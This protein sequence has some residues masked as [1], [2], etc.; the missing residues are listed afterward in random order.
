ML[1]KIF[2]TTSL[3]C[4]LF[5][6][7]NVNGQP[8][9]TGVGIR[10]GGIASGISVRHYLSS[11]GAIEGLASFG[12]HA[13]IITGLYESFH[14]F[15]NAEGLSWF[16]GGGA[17]VGFYQD[18]YRYEY[19]YY[20]SHN[21]KTI[22]YYEDGEEQFSFGGDFI[23]GMDYKFKNTPIDISLDVKPMIDFVPGL[24]GYW[25]GAISFRFT[26]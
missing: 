26:L 6:S 22:K 1:K 17:H 19:F 8:Y 14:A 12:R 3:L 16:F 23:I 13:F 7:N 11:K 18:E 5:L 15:P 25:E 10:F 20:K 24:Y 21:N 9:R 4:L 2:I